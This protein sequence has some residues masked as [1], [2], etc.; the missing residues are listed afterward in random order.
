M[1]EK[2]TDERLAQP[3]FAVVLEQTQGEVDQE[4]H[5]S[6]V[7]RT[8]PQLEPSRD[9]QDVYDGAQRRKGWDVGGHEG[10]QSR[11]PSMMDDAQHDIGPEPD[12]VRGGQLYPCVGHV[13]PSAPSC[14]QPMMLGEI[15][16]LAVWHDLGR[17]PGPG[18]GTCRRE[19]RLPVRCP[20]SLA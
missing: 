18:R 2:S 10:V 12:P 11:R 15:V 16:R 6:W 14:E 7:N 20:S 13:F 4:A 3:G 1:V 17:W 5:T 19:G 8:T 9:L